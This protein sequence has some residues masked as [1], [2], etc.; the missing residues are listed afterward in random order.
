MN[1]DVSVKFGGSTA[2]L[3]EAANKAKK[4]IQ[5]VGTTASG[6]KGVF[7]SV[8]ASLKNMFSGTN[9]SDVA[10]K[11]RTVRSE[12]RGLADGASTGNIQF[13]ALARTISEAA[14]ACAPLAIALAGVAVAL[15]GVYAVKKVLEFGEAMGE[16]ALEINKASVKLGMSAE[17]VQR[18]H[19]VATQ[20]GISTAQMD[21]GLV[22][23]ERSIYRAANGGKAQADAFTQLGISVKDLKG[24]NDALLK[25]SDAMKEKMS[26]A[27][28]AAKRNAI[29]MTLMSRTGSQMLPVMVE[30]SKAL[31]DMM[32][33]ADD[34]GSVMN[35]K[36]VNAGLAVDE[37]FKQLHMVGTG[38]KNM[39]FDALAP[40][41]N[42]IVSG[43]VSLGKRLIESYRNGGVVHAMVLGL[44]DVFKILAT[45]VLIV[46]GVFVTFSQIAIGALKAVW[47]VAAGLAKV[48]GDLM[49][50]HAAQAWTDA[51][52][53]IHDVGNTLKGT[54]NGAWESVKGTAKTVA[55]VWSK[56]MPKPDHPLAADEAEDGMD[57][58]GPGGKGKKGKDD[59]KKI[60]KDKLEAYLAELDEEEKAAEDDYAA[61][62]VIEQKK[63]DAIEQFYHKGSKEYQDQLNK[64]KDMERDHLKQLDA[65]EKERLQNQEKLRESDLNAAKEVADSK[66]QMER[67]RLDAEENLGH[68]SATQKAKE[69][70]HL[71]QQE[72]QNEIDHE[73]QMYASKVEEYR[74]ELAL[75]HLSVDDQRKINADLEQLE[76]D[77]VNKMV[78]IA[79][80]GLQQTAKAEQ[81]IFASTVQKM[82]SIL[83]PVAQ[84]FNN[85]LQG[86]LTR[87]MT[88][89]QG[90]I[91]LADGVV[92]ALVSSFV[93]MAEQ[94]AAQELA[95]TAATATGTAIRTSMEET[96]AAKS[97]LASAVACIKQIAH[98]AAV[99]AANVYKAIS[100]IPY[101][102]PF[103]APAMAGA[104]LIAV[105]KFG[106]KIASA[107]GGYDIPA[108]TNPMTQLHEKE[109]VLPANIAEPLRASLR[110]AGPRSQLAFSAM[111]GADASSTRSDT[112][113]RGGDAHM[114]Y[115]PTV[116]GGY[117]S[118]EE[119]LEHE[120]RYMRK[121]LKREHRSGTFETMA[122]PARKRA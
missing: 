15:A 14:A 118:L 42:A 48:M 66:I 56:S 77:H 10:S 112:A 59:S 85:M 19:A 26:G 63:L 110:G 106:S 90:L 58:A 109:M 3:D 115:A 95:K 84:G 60:A 2:G 54:L 5:G 107:R 104:A 91:Q 64:M 92:T 75:K 80:R 61:K 22:R 121:W 38:I 111:A 86:M 97:I 99:T 55:G 108:G 44:V 29:A 89:K 83:D 36:L 6:L 117:K 78:V 45:V 16:T 103:L 51:K 24:P 94:W 98:A 30:G 8:G 13:G 69:E 34:T 20:A 39:F 52:A 88:W 96:A 79:Q 73:N 62:M 76:R 41:I 81:T 35:N 122:K 105:L 67:D 57:L 87:T 11:M 17:Q 46:G 28:E 27:S 50:G 119:M 37:Q 32:A 71:D 33:A 1:E 74:A 25:I 93:N 4:D 114:T 101:V 102:G 72:L 7:S 21:S 70:A 9:Y 49:S 65:I 40:A 68:I 100:A 53:G 47:D 113:L 31:Q 43:L 18:W 82:K 116:H 23:L 12:V 120:A